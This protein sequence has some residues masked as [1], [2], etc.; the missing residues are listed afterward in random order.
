MFLDGGV[1]FEYNTGIFLVIV[2][3]VHCVKNN[4]FI[5]SQLKYNGLLQPG[6]FIGRDWCIQEVCILIVLRGE[7]ICRY[8]CV[9]EVCIRFVLR[10]ESIHAICRYWCFQEVCIGIVL[11]GE[12]ICRCWCVQEVC[13]Q[14]VL[15]TEPICRYWCVQEVCIQIV[16]R[17]ES[18]TCRENQEKI[19]SLLSY[20]PAN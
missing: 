12:P 18:R 4:N 15:R 8:W 17:G 14:I 10:G 13:I 16:L 7:P 11:R 20:L 9:Q 2:S 19:Q 6:V 3:Y 1:Y 5:L